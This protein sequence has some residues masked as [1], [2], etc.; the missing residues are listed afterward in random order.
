MRADSH[1]LNTLKAVKEILRDQ[2]VDFLFIDS[3]H[4][5]DDVK[6]DFEMYS[7]LVR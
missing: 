4:I 7:P 3:D 1:D 5:C 6:K 2:K